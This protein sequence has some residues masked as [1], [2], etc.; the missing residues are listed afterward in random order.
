MTTA[1]EMGKVPPILVHHRL[2]IA[3]EFAG[4]EQE[5]LAELIGVSRNTISNA[6]NGRR[7]PRRITLNAWALATGVP[8][9]WFLLPCEDLNL[10]PFGLRS[11]DDAEDD[12]AA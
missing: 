6:E 9:S 7:K 8:V 3:R 4:L 5:Q 10:E 2:R 11:D 1:Y 12:E